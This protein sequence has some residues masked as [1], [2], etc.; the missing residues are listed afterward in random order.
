MF[1]VSPVNFVGV[2]GHYVDFGAV[3][4]QDKEYVRNL[5]RRLGALSPDVI[6]V[7]ESVSRVA[8]EALAKGR[9]AVVGL[10]KPFPVQFV[11]P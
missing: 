1:L 10:V 8:A 3:F 11:R 2:E 9:V 6:L 5:H 7:D 4:P